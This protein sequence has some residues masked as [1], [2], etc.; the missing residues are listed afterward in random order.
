MK[1][2]DEAIGRNIEC[3]RKGL[4]FYEPGGGGNYGKPVI[5]E[6]EKALERVKS[7]FEQKAKANRATQKSLAEF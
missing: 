7:E 2:V 5:C 1:R 4:V 6:N 3:F